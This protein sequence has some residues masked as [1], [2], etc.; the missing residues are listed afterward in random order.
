MHECVLHPNEQTLTDMRRAQLIDV[1]C[2]CKKHPC[3]CCCQL[4]LTSRP[5]M[6][7]IDTCTMQQQ[8]WYKNSGI[9]AMA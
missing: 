7:G 4:R 6:P 9:D 2:G 8:Q 3:C 1:K 5:S